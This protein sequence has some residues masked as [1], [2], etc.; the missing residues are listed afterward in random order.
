MHWQEVCDDRG[1]LFPCKSPTGLGNPAIAQRRRN[2]QT[3]EGEGLDEGLHHGDFVY[4]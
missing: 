4:C 3:M 1:C 2:C